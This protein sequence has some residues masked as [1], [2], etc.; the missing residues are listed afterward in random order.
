MTKPSGMVL[1]SQQF[2]IPLKVIADRIQPQWPEILL[3]DKCHRG[4]K[5]ATSRDTCHVEEIN[6]NETSKL[7]TQF[8]KSERK[9]YIYTSFTIVS[10]NKSSSVALD[11]TMQYY[12]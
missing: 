2:T 8:N 12:L 1:K 6:K 3:Y 4:L 10:G 5:W 7:V 9:L 11:P